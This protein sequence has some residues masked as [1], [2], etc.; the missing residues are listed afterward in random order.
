LGLIWIKP[1]YAGW[2]FAIT[3]VGIPLYY[4]AVANRKSNPALAKDETIKEDV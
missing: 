1:A 2:G 3:L 4:I